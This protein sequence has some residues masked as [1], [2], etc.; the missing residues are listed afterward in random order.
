MSVKTLYRS[1]T[2]ACVLIALV[3]GAALASAPSLHRG[4][5]YVSNVK[6]KAFITLITSAT[7][8]RT[9]IAGPVGAVP[10]ASQFPDTIGVVRCPKAKRERGAPRS[11]T[12]SALFGFPGATLKRSHGRYSFSVSRTI[13]DQTV[14]ESTA[15]PFT[16]NVH[17][18]GV[19]TGAKSITGKMSVSGGPCTIKP[20]AYTAKL[21]SEKVA[22]GN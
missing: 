10:I 18:T 3:A 4:R 2:A 21:S 14:F 17:V 11:S 8:A 7:N 12:P 20:L 19:V 5:A 22:P 16:L 6:A 13:H 1:A 15:K 9:L